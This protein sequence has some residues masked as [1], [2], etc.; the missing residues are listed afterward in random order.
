MKL[1]ETLKSKRFTITVNPIIKSNVLNT[2]LFSLFEGLFSRNPFLYAY[3]YMIKKNRIVNK[4]F[5]PNT[6]SA[7]KN[8]EYVPIKEVVKGI[9]DMQAKYNML[10]HK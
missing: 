2:Y 7:R 10:I 1:L 9:N 5:I 4:I 8:R 3:E 6:T